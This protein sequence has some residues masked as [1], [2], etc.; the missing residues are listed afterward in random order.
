MNDIEHVHKQAFL[1][2]LLVV[3]D[4]VSFLKFFKLNE[5]LFKRVLNITSFNLLEIALHPLR[6]SSIESG[7][8]RP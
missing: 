4:Q 3:N 1:L 7:S 5:P 8:D 2:S 6:E